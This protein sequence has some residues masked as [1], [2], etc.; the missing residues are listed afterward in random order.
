MLR[1]WLSLAGLIVAAGSLF[2][3]LLLFV[4]DSVAHFTNPYIGI[5]TYSVAPGF[6]F[7]GLFLALIGAWWQRHRIKAVAEIPRLLIDFA[8]PRHRRN[9][10]FCACFLL[11]SALGSY[12]TYE[13]TE[14]V[15]FCGEAC[16]TVM[17]PEYMAC[18]NGPHARVACAQCHIGP[19]ATW[20]VRSKLSGTYH[21]RRCFLTEEAGPVTSAG[22]GLFIDPPVRMPFRPAPEVSQHR[23]F[24]RSGSWDAFHSR[25]ALRTWRVAEV[26]KHRHV[27]CAASRLQPGNH[28]GCRI[29][30]S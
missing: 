2:S 1:N 10:G 24:C 15:Q 4:L 19:G 27:R 16:H 25:V 8:N 18:L 30:A 21:D 17:K 29:A 11:I 22:L 26:R 5:L 14:S 12:Q 7:L 23:C 9:L 20:Y 13:Y 6:L 28:S 3:F